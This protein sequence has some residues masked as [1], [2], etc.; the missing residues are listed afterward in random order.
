M[1]TILTFTENLNMCDEALR[2]IQ[3]NEMLA[4]SK[5]ILQFSFV[6]NSFK[7]LSIYVEA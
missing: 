7:D 1:P 5:R 4:K 3:N 6:R 2:L